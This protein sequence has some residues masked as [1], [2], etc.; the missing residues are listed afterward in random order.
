MKKKKNLLRNT[1]SKLA[2]EHAHDIMFGILSGTGLTVLVSAL[3]TL[4]A[5][6][7]PLF[8]PYYSIAWIALFVFILLFTSLWYSKGWFRIVYLTIS[9]IWLLT[10]IYLN[11][12]K[13]AL[14]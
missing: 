5:I 7:I 14:N 6:I 3:I 9:L 4:V 2:E 13:G 1:S 10:Y 12:I 8:Y 11:L